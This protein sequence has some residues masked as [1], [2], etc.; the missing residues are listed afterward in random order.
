[1]ERKIIVQA[2]D[3][4]KV[5]SITKDIDITEGSNKAT[6]EFKNILQFINFKFKNYLSNSYKTLIELEDEGG[7][8]N[9]KE[10]SNDNLLM[11]DLQNGILKFKNNCN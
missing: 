2:L 8:R 6:F 3:K 1:M 5:V 9:Y 4:I 10:I 11:E 7:T